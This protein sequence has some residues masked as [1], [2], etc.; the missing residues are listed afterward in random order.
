M[1][2]FVQQKFE[3]REA[4]W[5]AKLNNGEVIYQDD[6]RP[7]FNPP[8]AWLRLKDYCRKESLAIREIGL[9]FRSHEEWGFLPKNADAYFFSRSAA[10]IS[11]YP[12]TLNFYLLGAVMNGELLIQRW[13][14]PELLCVGTQSRPIVPGDNLIEFPD[15]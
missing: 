7:F 8:S 12:E 3:R 9:K 1:D 11:G 14:V 10:A 13:Q 4:I 15:R 5:I 6:S 2:E